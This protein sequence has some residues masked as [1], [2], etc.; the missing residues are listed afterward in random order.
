MNN[1]GPDMARFLKNV[2]MREKHCRTWN[3][4]KTLNTGK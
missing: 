4:A 3:M 2:E 1:V